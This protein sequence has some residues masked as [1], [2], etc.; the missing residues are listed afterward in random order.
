MRKIV[1][2]KGMEQIPN[3]CKSCG[4][5]FRVENKIFFKHPDEYFCVFRTEPVTFYA[6]AGTRSDYCPLRELEVPDNA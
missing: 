5:C 2:I 3:S 1:Y 4:C 6:K